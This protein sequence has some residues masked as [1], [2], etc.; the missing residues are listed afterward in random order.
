MSAHARPSV[1]SLDS[2]FVTARHRDTD[3]GFLTESVADM[4]AVT[5]DGL[6]L[7]GQVRGRGLSTAAIVGVSTSAAGGAS[8]HRNRLQGR[9]G[10]G[11]D[12]DEATWIDLEERVG[13][14]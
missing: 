3:D 12:G 10:R 4:L 9:R 2:T 7:A 6:V 5:A 8:L 13:E 11:P 14:G 1:A